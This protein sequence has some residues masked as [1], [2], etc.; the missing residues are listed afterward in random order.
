LVFWDRLLCPLPLKP[1]ESG[2]NQHRRATEKL[3]DG[4]AKIVLEIG[5]RLRIANF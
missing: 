4:L 3:A 1:N 2:A 5:A